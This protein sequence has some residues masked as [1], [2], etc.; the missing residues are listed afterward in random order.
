MSLLRCPF[1]ARQ[2]MNVLRTKSTLVMNYAR[3]C[4]VMSRVLNSVH[5]R[6]QFHTSGNVLSKIIII[7][8]L[9]VHLYLRC[10]LLSLPSLNRE[11]MSKVI[12]I[13]K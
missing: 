1:L 12:L 2:P 3:N 9:R 10:I 5:P 7:V 8:H 13:M 11:R 6:S 4:P